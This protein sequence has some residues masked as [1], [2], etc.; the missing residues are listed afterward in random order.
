MARFVCDRCKTTW[1]EGEARCPRCLRKT[2]VRTLDRESSSEAARLASGDQS[3]TEG[4]RRATAL[5]VAI[6]ANVASG[7]AVSLAWPTLT[8]LA[9]VG[10]AAFAWAVAGASWI[11]A[12]VVGVP[13][14][15]VFGRRCAIAA[16]LGAWAFVSTTLALVSSSDLS[17][18]F[19]VGLAAISFGAG[20][21]GC[22]WWMRSRDEPDEP[23]SGKW[24]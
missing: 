16:A 3:Q 12:A 23:P 8:S 5:L 18:P 13:S 11:G 7:I 22:L 21:V 6:A 17:A 2:S 1:D 14:W 24:R 19:T 4:A 10:P 15:A 20:V 9:L